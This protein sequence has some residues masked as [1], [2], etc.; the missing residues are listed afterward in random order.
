MGS[1]Y[2]YRILQL[3]THKN[4]YQSSMNDR[5]WKIILKYRINHENLLKNQIQDSHVTVQ[6]D[7]EF[8]LESMTTDPTKQVRIHLYK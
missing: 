1:F 2:Q 7:F 3:R 6:H 4:Y 8:N 5:S